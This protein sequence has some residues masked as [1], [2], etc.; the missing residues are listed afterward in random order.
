M[1]VC[2]AKKKVM[3][4]QNSL[5]KEKNPLTKIPQTKEIILDFALTE[6]GE[7]S[8][9]NYNSPQKRQ[10]NNFLTN[11]PLLLSINS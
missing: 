2:Q 4:T 10:I 11:Q 1:G 3:I 7:D 5:L 9:L 8:K 6:P